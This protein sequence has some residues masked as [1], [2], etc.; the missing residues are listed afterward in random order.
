MN[1]NFSLVMMGAHDGSK[2]SSFILECAARGNVLLVEPVPYLFER[3]SKRFAGTANITCLNEAISDV[4]G[5][6]DFYMPAADSNAI[7]SYGDQLGSLIAGHAESHDSRFAEKIRKIKCKSRTMYALL[8]EFDIREIDVLWTDM[9][10]YDATCLMSFPFYLV[11]PRQIF[12]EAKH[13]DGMDRIGKK[14]ATFLLFL[15][16]LKYRVKLHDAAN[17]FAVYSP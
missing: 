15:E 5:E 8:A 4:I 6:V 10:G 7:T 2:T 13:S 14:F 12:I 3:L 16:E 17:C 1:M 9:E 11:K